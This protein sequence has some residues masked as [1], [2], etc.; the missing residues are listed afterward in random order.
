[1]P[2][3]ASSLPS[4]LAPPLPSDEQ[5]RPATAL[6]RP[7]RQPDSLNADSH[8]SD[9]SSHAGGGEAGGSAARDATVILLLPEAGRGGGGGGGGGK[10]AS[11]HLWDQSSSS[12]V[13]DEDSQDGGRIS[14]HQA[15]SSSSLSAQD[16]TTN[17]ASDTYTDLG[18]SDGGGSSV[19]IV[20]GSTAS[21]GVYPYY[22]TTRL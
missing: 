11:R 16:P 2:L 18:S 14:K 6:R 1:M 19:R 12:S 4:H 8:H 22:G 5:Y 21:P 13:T 15:I 3:E 10:L 7:K 9:I 20:G 17:R